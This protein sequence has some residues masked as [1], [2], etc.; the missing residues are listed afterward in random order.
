MS[1]VYTLPMGFLDRVGLLARGKYITWRKKG[2]PAPSEP[3]LLDRELEQPR[4]T[5]PRVTPS[6]P[7]DVP[8]SPDISMSRGDPKNP[9]KRTL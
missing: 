6:A 3:D 1:G 7:D 4:A 8:A 5:S 9:K 2:Q